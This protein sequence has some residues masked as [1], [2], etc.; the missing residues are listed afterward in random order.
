MTEKPGKIRID[1]LLLD[2]GFV[3]SI[4]E[5][6]SLVMTGDVLVNNVPVKKSGDLVDPSANIRIRGERTPFVSRGGLKLDHAIKKFHLDVREKI[7]LDVGASTGGFT[8]CLLQNGAAR[9]YAVDVG[10]GQMDPKI[11]KDKRVVVIDRTNVRDLNEVLIPEPIDVA[12]IDVSFISLEKVF[13]TIDRFVHGG[14]IIVALVKP[15]FEVEKEKVGK[16]G[17]VRD[18]SL[19][20]EAVQKVIA[21]AALLNWKHVGLTESPILGAKGNREF[22]AVSTK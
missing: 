12:V 9:V 21:A 7:C 1:K 4:K 15:Q 13:P 18:K 19:H 10:Y 22:L 14:S 8:D 11:A 3:S 16:G 20:D 6:A 2:L 5:A 17:I